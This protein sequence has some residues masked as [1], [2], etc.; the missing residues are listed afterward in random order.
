MLTLM[1][2]TRNV[3]PGRHLNDELFKFQV[4]SRK[5][6]LC[7]APFSTHHPPAL[8]PTICIKVEWLVGSHM[9]ALN[10]PCLSNFIFSFQII[11][12]TSP[13]SPALKSASTY[14][15]TRKKKKDLNTAS[16]RIINLWTTRELQMYVASNL[17]ELVITMYLY[18]ICHVITKSLR[19]YV[20][21]VNYGKSRKVIS[22]RPLPRAC[23]GPAGIHRSQLIEGFRKS[24]SFKGQ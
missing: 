2:R 4:A 3:M 24:L 11:L 6:L 18:D 12:I 7:S 1:H 23:A 10:N 22:F 16:Y 8:S 19:G 17:H 15:C 5:S 13:S 21:L 9:H 20:S 14:S